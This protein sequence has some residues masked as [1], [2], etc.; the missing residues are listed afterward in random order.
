MISWPGQIAMYGRIRSRKNN[1]MSAILSESWC[2]WSR[3]KYL[4]CSFFLLFCCAWLS[5]I[6]HFLIWWVWW[7]LPK[8]IAHNDHHH[9]RIKLIT[10]LVKIKRDFAETAFIFM[11]TTNY[12]RWY[13]MKMESIK[14]KGITNGP[15]LVYVV[16]NAVQKI[17][18]D[19]LPK[20]YAVI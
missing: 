20:F 10:R 16:S 3:S 15:V 6:T 17:L 19:Y 9:P 11:E 12:C 8:A 4:Q 18:P 1:D 7:L 14:I 2:W 13:T 5:L